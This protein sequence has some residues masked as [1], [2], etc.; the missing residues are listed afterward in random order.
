MS[1]DHVSVRDRGFTLADG[2]FETMRT[3]A[4]VV[5][6]LD[7]HLARLANG[8]RVMQIPEPHGLKA[9]I[10]HRVLA[11]A[12]W[13]SAV[14]VTVTRGPGP[15]GLAPPPEAAPTVVVSVNPLPQFPPALYTHGLRVIIASGRRNSRS[16]SAGLKT[17]SYTDSV[18]AWLEAQR[19]GADDAV[20]LDEDGHC[21]EGTASNLFVLHDGVLLT[22]P[23]T[24]AALPG[25]TRAAVLEL[26]TNAGIGTEERAFGPQELLSAREVFLTSSLRGIAP[27]TSVNTQPVGTG[28]AGTVTARLIAAYTALIERECCRP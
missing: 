9:T 13:E 8:L 14:R 15:G 3:R 26:A 19:A 2:L 12:A 11:T 21:S 25:L 7:R 17:L 10:E 5:F 6:R 16:M 20:F 23:V 1:P 22:P 28:E 24:C 27:V 18:L 4:G